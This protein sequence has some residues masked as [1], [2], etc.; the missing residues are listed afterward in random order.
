[1]SISNQQK[2]SEVSRSVMK[3][4]GRICPCDATNGSEPRPSIS[5]GRELG[6]LYFTICTIDGMSNFHD[7]FLSG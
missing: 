2:F 1:M 4:L 3:I 7:S 6:W 5:H